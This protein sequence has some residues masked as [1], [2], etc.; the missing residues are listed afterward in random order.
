MSIKVNARSRM[1]KLPIITFYRLFLHRMA[2]KIPSEHR[3]K[4]G[5]LYNVSLT[6]R[7][8]FWRNSVLRRK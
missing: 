5:S 4:L 2:K 8:S 1:I 7:E 3:N 6:F